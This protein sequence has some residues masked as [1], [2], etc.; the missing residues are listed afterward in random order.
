MNFASIK[1]KLGRWNWRPRP[2]D[3]RHRLGRRGERAAARFLKRRG[4]RIV[5]RN[6]RCEAGEIDLICLDAPHVVFVEVKCRA[7]DEAQ[8][9]QDAVRTTQW[10]RIE[11]AARYFLRRHAAGDRPC[12]F[13][14]VTVHWPSNGFRRIQHFEDA[15]SPRR[16]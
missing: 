16:P 9:P 13:D 4:Q 2:H 3:P 1:R 14:L 10:R 11:G 12:R 15:H 5:A 7:G 8:E 6:Y